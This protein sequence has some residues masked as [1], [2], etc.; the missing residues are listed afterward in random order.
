MPQYNEARKMLLGARQ[1]P[2]PNA[3]ATATATQIKAVK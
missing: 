2:N 1:N 3:F